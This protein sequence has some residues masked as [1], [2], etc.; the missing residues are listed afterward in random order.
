MINRNRR[1]F[2]QS[3]V[4]IAAVG[5]RVKPKEP[6]VREGFSLE[7]SSN[8]VNCRKSSRRGGRVAE[9]GGLLNRCTG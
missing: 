1:D 5:H 4:Y 2:Q 3:G 9:C 6:E 7:P 8:V